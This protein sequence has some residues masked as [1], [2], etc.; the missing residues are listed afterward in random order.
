MRI[1]VTVDT[2]ADD[3]W[4][5]AKGVTIDNVFGLDRFQN[6]CERYSMPPTYLLAYEVADDA[7]AAE[8]FKA[9]KSKGVEIGSHLH[10]WTTPP[11]SAAD[12]TSQSFPSELSDEE[13]KSKLTNLT[14]KVK[15]ISS[16]TPTSYRAGRWGFDARDARILEDLGYEVDL[17]ITPGLTW[18]NT[19]GK[20]GGVG[21]PDFTKENVVPRMLNKS[22][23]EVPMTILPTGLFRRNRWLRIFENTTVGQLRAVIKAARKKQLPAIV[24]MTHSSELMVGKSPYVKTPAALEHSYKCI[25]GLFEACAEESISGTTA[26][27]FAREYKKTL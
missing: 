2:E 13:F 18:K 19:K 14:E 7:R 25:E 21:G 16:E 9:W 6:L 26:T 24:F 15:A 4:N 22:V 10:P 17:S 8:Q 20:E 1:I 3:Q 23:L 11:F 12:E 5:R 27:E